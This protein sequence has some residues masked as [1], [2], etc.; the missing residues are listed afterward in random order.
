MNILIRLPNWLGDLVMSTAFVRSLQHTYPDATIDVIIKK[1]IDTVVDY[2]PGIHKKW[3]FSKEEFRGLRGARTFGRL[4]GHEVKPDLFFCLPDSFSSA[5][6]AKATGAAKRIGYKNELRSF[7]LTK[8]KT[9]DSSL[10]RVDQYLALLE[11]QIGKKVMDPKVF[12]KNEQVLVP[13]RIIINVNSEA[14]SRRLPV[15]KAIP[16]IELLRSR[17]DAELVMVGSP[18]ELPHVKQVYDGLSNKEGVI[19]MAGK[20]NMK[21]LIDLFCTAPVMLTTDSGPMHLAN[22]LGV[23]TV[24]LEGASD[25]KNTAP[26]NAQKR[27]LIRY[28]Q[29]PCE[30]C[31]KN[32][33][34][35]GTPTCLLKMDNEVI[36][37]SVVAVSALY[38]K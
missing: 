10:H 13:N 26:Y 36:V 29:L 37:R 6:M 14:D 38:N 35:F 27:T 23:H 1:G 15:E 28:G 25:E 33:C 30:P 21:E 8:S 3:V 7:L 16:V 19:N 4:V 22:A 9:K 31:V 5:W 24:A 17:T 11:L 12:L 20:T 2:L 34:Q 18:K 32:T